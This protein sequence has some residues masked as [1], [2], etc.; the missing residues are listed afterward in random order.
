MA[1]LLCFRFL[2]DDVHLGKCADL[3]VEGNVWDGYVVKAEDNSRRVLQSRPNAS[4]R[5]SD[6]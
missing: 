3:L 5:G 2:I 4:K 6:V 1:G